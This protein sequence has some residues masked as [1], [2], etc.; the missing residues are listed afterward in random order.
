M[1]MAVVQLGGHPVTIRP[2]EIGLDTR[3]TVEDVTRTPGVLPRRDRAP[4]SSTITSSSGWPPCRPC[5][6]STCCRTTPIPCRRW[7]T[8]SRSQ[9]ARFARGPDGRYVGD[10]N[11]VGPVAWPSRRGM[12]GMEV[13]IAMSA[14]LRLSD[15]R[16]RLASR[17]TRHRAA[18]ARTIPEEAVAGAD[19][20]YTDVWTSM[21]L[22]SEGDPRREAF[23]GL[24]GRRRVDGAAADHVAIFIHCLPAHR[25]EEVTARVLDGTAATS[26]CRPRTACTAPRP[27]GRGSRPRATV[28]SRRNGPT[29]LGKT[30]RST[31]SPS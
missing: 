16:R 18:R 24:H 29:K 5:P 17:K 12:S 2:D 26:C 23:E 25:G 11:N 8:C 20:V 13:R 15:S 3:E 21:G 7:P 9:Q 4:A 28:M 6:S 14:R 1:E 30:Q 22:E 31:S 10:G 19:A 27:H